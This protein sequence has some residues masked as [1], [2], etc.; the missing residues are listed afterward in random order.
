MLHCPEPKQRG[1]LLF[2][3]QSNFFGSNLDNWMILVIFAI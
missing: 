3:A 1:Q 2:Y